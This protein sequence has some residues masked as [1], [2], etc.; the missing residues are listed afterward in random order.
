MSIGASSRISTR[1][2][3]I[4]VFKSSGL[5]GVN[6]VRF[7][8]MSRSAQRR[9]IA[10]SKSN[11]ANGEIIWAAIVSG[12][13]RGLFVNPRFTYL[14]SRWIAR[15]GFRH[16]LLGNRMGKERGGV[17]IGRWRFAE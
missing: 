8:L 17:R 13:Q 11:L 9:R 7:A 16:G 6:F 4:K 15:N 12:R 2:I 10:V 5:T 14:F 1:P 3:S